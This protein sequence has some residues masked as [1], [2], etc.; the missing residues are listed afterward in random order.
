MNR[1]LTSSKANCR[2]K[3]KPNSVKYGKSLSSISLIR[4]P[5]IGSSNTIKPSSRRDFSATSSSN[6]AIDDISVFLTVCPMTIVRDVGE[7]FCSRLKRFPPQTAGYCWSYRTKLLFQQLTAAGY[8][9][10][11]PQ[12]A[13]DRCHCI[14]C[15]SGFGHRDSCYF[16][17][18]IDIHPPWPL[19]RRNG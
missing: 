8:M 10:V 17:H 1:P 3:S 11:E 19:A 12:P 14:W 9:S 13:R 6:V 15:T 2:Q 18:K 16:L 5:T 7:N 4:L